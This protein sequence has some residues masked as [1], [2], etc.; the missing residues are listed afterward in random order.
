MTAS[1]TGGAAAAG[2]GTVDRGQPTEPAREPLQPQREERRQ[3]LE[4]EP[5]RG[6]TLNFQGPVLGSPEEFARVVRR[7]IDKLD[8]RGYNPG[9][10]L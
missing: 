4:P 3:A 7:E 1:P 2:A 5:A 10:G 9:K 8:R 6:I